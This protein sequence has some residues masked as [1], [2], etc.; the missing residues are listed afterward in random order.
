[1]SD[2]TISL[3]IL[4]AVVLVFIWNKLP[5]GLVAII[6]ALTLYA[7]GLLSLE[8]SLAGFGD[9]VVV[10][11]A[12]LF[13][14]S[15]GIDS[16]GVTTWAGRWLL[17]KVG[18][19]PKVALVAIMAMAAVMSALISLNGAAAALIPMIVVMAMRLG[20]KPGRLLMPMAFAGSAGALLI[21][22]GSPVNVLVSQAAADSGAGAFSFFSFTIVGVPLVLVT[23]L[24]VA[25]L[26]PRVL[27]D[28]SSASQPPD[29]SDHARELAEHYELV[30][31]FYR[32]KLT[33]SSSLIGTP[34][35]S[36]SLQA[37]PA[38]RLIAAQRGLDRLTGSTELEAGD[39]VVVTGPEAEATSL[40]STSGLDVTMRP[41]TATGALLDRDSGLVELVIPPRSPL[42]GETMFPGMKRGADLVVLG[43]R[44]RGRELGATA[45][46]LEEGDSLLVH[47][48]WAAVEELVDHRDVLVVNSPDQ[49]RRQA[50]PLGAKAPVAIAVLAVMIVLLAAN[51][52]PPAA[53]GLGAAAAM[54]LFRVVSAGQA[55]RAVSWQTVILI[56]GLI[57]L[58]TAIQTSGAAE[59]ISDKLVAVVGEGHPILVLLA[60]FALTAL[61]G[62]FISNTATVLIIIPIAV[63]AASESGVS[64]L[65]ILMAVAVAGS[66]SFLTPVSTPANMMVLGP[67]GYRFGDYWKLGAPLLLAWLLVALLIIPRV[68]PL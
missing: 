31:G 36:L 43:I 49:L 38:L 21:L 9:P 11:I 45:S 46:L 5:V 47:G 19:N 40:A 54:V 48:S 44:R 60:L 34:W 52:V 13:V 16:A 2:A 3:L 41:V 62:Q 20:V 12:S 33:T 50:V 58:S 59:L 6:T 51:V 4:L 66:A 61:L 18:G 39:V 63:A 29:L 32:L 53:A 26:G 25:V 65:P 30:D 27:P 55:A 14:V 24:V 64:P 67:G 15:E 28:R 37:F 22:T 68:W 17:D 42:V 1:M 35:G 57:P 23:I 56:G 10:F 8:Q 7:T